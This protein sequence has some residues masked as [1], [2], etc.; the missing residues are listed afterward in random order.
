MIRLSEC[1]RLPT[2]SATL[3]VTVETALCVGAGGTSGT[4]ADKPIVRT[5]ADRLLIP[6]SQVK[7]RLRHECEKLLRSLQWPICESPVAETMCPERAGLTEQFHQDRY[8]LS[9]ALA[10]YP[11]AKSYHC[12]ACQLFGNPTLPA[13]VIFDDLVCETSPDL[14]AEVLRPGVTLSRTRRTAV[15]QRFFLLETSPAN[16]ALKFSGEVVFTPESPNYGPAL[17]TAALRHVNALGGSKSAGL[18]WLTAKLDAGDQRLTLD[19]LR[20]VI[21]GTDV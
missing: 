6:A 5:A 15:E 21:G 12:Y 16:L 17:I 14:L 20:P 2:S 11:E 18:G 7:G 3:S 19:A 13:R 10:G 9:E 4:L 8:R 1:D